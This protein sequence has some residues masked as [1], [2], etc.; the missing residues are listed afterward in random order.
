MIVGCSEENV[1]F[2]PED[3]EGAEKK[4]DTEMAERVGIDK[5]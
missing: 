5:V 4:A 3:K 1:D 2:N